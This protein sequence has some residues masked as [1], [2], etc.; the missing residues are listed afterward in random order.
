MPSTDTL[1]VLLHPSIPQTKTWKTDGTIQAH[2]NG[3]THNL[4]SK[5]VD[6]IE[7]LSTVLL[8][9]ENDPYAVVIRGEYLGHDHAL[10]EYPGE[11]E[12]GKV[13]RRKSLFRDVP[14]HWLMIDVDGYVTERE[15]MV[16][17]VGAV[18]E[19]IEGNLPTQF[20]GVS[21]HWQLSASFG[22][23]TKKGLRVHIWAWSKT[24]YMSEQLRRWAE[25]V[26]FKGD[27]TL[28]STIQLHY[29]A[30]PVFED[31]VDD[32]VEMR[33]GFIEGEFGD[34]VDLLIPD[35][36]LTACGG[37]VPVSRQVKAREVWE[38]DAV[39]KWLI[40]SVDHFKSHRRDGGLNIACLLDDEHSSDSG[41]SSTIYYPAHTNGYTRGTFVCLHSH[42]TEQGFNSRCH[43]KLRELGLDD[44]D[45][46][47]TSLDNTV[48]LLRADQITPEAISWLWTEWLARGKLI[49]SAGSPG[50]GK[51]TLAMAMVATVT[52]GGKW[53]DGTGSERGSVVI[54]SGEDDPK[55]TLVPRLLACNADLSRVHFVVD[56]IGP[57][58]PRP[59]DPARDMP[60]LQSQVTRIGDVR[61]IVVDPIVSAVAGDSHKN[62]EVRRGL[63]P[64]VDLASKI[65]A[66][67]IG[68]THFT[69]GTGGKDTT[70]R[71]TGSLAFAALARVVLATA[72]DQNA[73]DYLI[74]RSKSNIGPDGGG[75]RYHIEQVDIPNH[76]G[77]T[78]SRVVWGDAVTGS[79][80]EL[81]A[82]T[83][84]EQTGQ[85][86]NAE[87]WLR[88]VLSFGPTPAVDVYRLGGG[89]GFSEK[90]L[91]RTLKKIGGTSEK[92]AFHGSW[93]WKLAGFE[94][95]EDAESSGDDGEL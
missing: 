5:K 2:G 87:N 27:P 11:V 79:A 66:C 71:V 78:A 24:P 86:D 21:V 39:A 36:I 32:P 48:N 72:K 37:T 50:T 22:H 12:Y 77:L 29:T 94:N 41:E 52:N 63:Q 55:D 62:A 81:I 93:V 80:R 26:D 3:K 74:T 31:G 92:S 6:N 1:T 43:D 25:R 13:L 47:F 33:S 54:W 61:L 34:V 35:D 40:N 69:K 85:T 16:D 64:L 84:G 10:K 58:G 17:P 30:A 91:Q 8:E 90:K 15:A 53:P 65:G 42:G 19:W 67:L 57:D 51:T 4:E 60:L 56:A 89:K 20:H 28:F 68:I 9:L 14:H 75:F 70:E 38:N 82:E 88:G 59:F 23:P 95:I 45:G 49:L 18:R 46:V 83:E 7:A 44:T 73:G 76:P